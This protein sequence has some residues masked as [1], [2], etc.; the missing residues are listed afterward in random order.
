MKNIRG[1]NK[2]R[3]LEHDEQVALFQ[4]AKLQEKKYPG[5]AYMFAIPN[6]GARNIVT[7][8]RLKAEGVRAGVP[9]I[10]LPFVK[11]QIDGPGNQCGGL[12]I[13]MKS[14]KNKVTPD[15]ARY[16][17]W[18]SCAGYSVIVCYSWGDAK[19]GILDYLTGGKKC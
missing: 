14:G 5:L 13:E 12:F 3:S 9:D 11:R 10:F 15:Q 16:H 17:N 2:R 4:W 8:T 19:N 1:K 7:A 6:G 18:L